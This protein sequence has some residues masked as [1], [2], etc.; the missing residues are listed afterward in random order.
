M[1]KEQVDEKFLAA[2][3]EQHLPANKG[4]TGSQLQ[5]KLSDMPYQ[6]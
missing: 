1:I 5:K 4:E 2:H 6:G 3:I